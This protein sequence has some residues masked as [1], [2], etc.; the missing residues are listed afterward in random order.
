MKRLPSGGDRA[1]RL[2]DQTANRS[3]THKRL[4]V[5]IIGKASVIDSGG[6]G[7][8]RTNDLTVISRA[9]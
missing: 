8:I 7:W 3:P 4:P 1:H 6:P 5:F 9:L 2:G